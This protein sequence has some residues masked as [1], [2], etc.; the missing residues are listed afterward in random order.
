MVSEL[1][2]IFDIIITF[3]ALISPY[4]I[5]YLNDKKCRVMIDLSHATL[6]N[7]L[8]HKDNVSGIRTSILNK[9]K[10]PIRISSISFFDLEIKNFFFPLIDKL[11]SHYMDILPKVLDTGDE[12]F[13]FL[14][15]EEFKLYNIS[16]LKAVFNI[17]GKRKYSKKFMVILK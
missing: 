7:M 17:N 6:F 16:T 15:Y 5:W 9:G 14:P 8:N 12:A 13:L 10:L 3:L 4:I 11:P 2:G 1:I